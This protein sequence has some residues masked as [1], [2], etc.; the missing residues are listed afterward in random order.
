VW[1]SWLLRS[2]DWRK[3]H[4]HRCQSCRRR[5]ADDEPGCIPPGEERFPQLCRCDPRP[6]LGHTDCRASGPYCPACAA[7]ITKEQREI[8]QWE[9]EW[10]LT[11]PSASP[12]LACRPRTQPARRRSGHSCTCHQCR[13]NNRNPSRAIGV[14]WRPGSATSLCETRSSYSARAPAGQAFAARWSVTLDDETR[15]PPV[16]PGMPTGVR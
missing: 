9:R 2:A 11:G 7:Q 12:R 8:D 13:G 15:R 16:S 5:F 1:L 14:I 10:L 6:D 3:I 4:V